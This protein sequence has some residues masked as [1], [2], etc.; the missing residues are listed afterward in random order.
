MRHT[1]V[2]LIVIVVSSVWTESQANNSET[3][4]SSKSKVAHPVKHSSADHS[5]KPHLDTSH[6]SDKHGHSQCLKSK[7]ED[8]PMSLTKKNEQKHDQKHGAEIMHTTISP[9]HKSIVHD[10]RMKPTTKKPEHKNMESAK[11]RI[12]T[13]TKTTPTTHKPAVTPI[14]GVIYF[15]MID[16]PIRIHCPMGQL[17]DRRGK[18]RVMFSN[19]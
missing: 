3:S 5:K 17:P 14:S 18:C 11:G 2:F 15:R 9:A 16:V 13:T 4:L 6:K 7:Q 12:T 19:K 10:S 8:K 1:W